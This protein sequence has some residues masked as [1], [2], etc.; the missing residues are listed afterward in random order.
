M[1]L[2]EEKAKSEKSEMRN[3]INNKE[4]DAVRNV[5]RRKGMKEIGREGNTY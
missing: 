1:M 2:K 4:E 3:R 5:R